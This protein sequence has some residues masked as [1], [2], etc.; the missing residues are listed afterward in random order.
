MNVLA[1]LRFALRAIRRTRVGRALLDFVGRQKPW[2][3]R[4]DCVHP[5]DWY[6]PI[7]LFFDKRI[8]AA[9]YMSRMSEKGWHVSVF[10]ER[11]A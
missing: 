5:H 3:F 4:V 10:G 8:D 11:W 6:S 2:Q 7:S 1:A 9:L